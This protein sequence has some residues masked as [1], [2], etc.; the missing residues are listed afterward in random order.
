MRDR[1]WIGTRKLL[2]QGIVTGCVLEIG[3]GPGYLGLEWLK[4]TQG[5]WLF[6]LEI[7]AGMIDAAVRNAREYGLAD[8]AKFV[9]GDGSRMSFADR[10]FDAVISTGSLHE[11]SDPLGTF[12]EVWR[13][14]KRG[15]RIRIADQ[16]R[17]ISSPVRCYLW[18]T[19]RP[20]PIRAGW[21]AALKA[22]YTP[23]ELRE[24]TKGTALE[25]CVVS[26]NS[27]GLALT[28]TR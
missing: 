17:D 25:N 7:D 5:T 20:A 16:R 19:R 6:G 13:V 21:M 23:D 9:L 8:R 18:L 14:L 27:M 22:S 10:T 24:L 26:N 15:G 11:W 2:S 4:N 12:N 1:G 3:P 28:G